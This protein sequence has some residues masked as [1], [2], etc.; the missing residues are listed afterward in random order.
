MSSGCFVFLR[1]LYPYS[2]PFPGCLKFEPNELFLK[3]REENEFWYLASKLDG[4]VGCVP[5]NYVKPDKQDDQAA[6]NCA[7]KALSQFSKSSSDLK[8]KEDILRILKRLAGVEN[9]VKQTQASKLYPEPRSSPPTRASFPQARQNHPLTPKTV[10]T[11]IAAQL[12]DVLRLGTNAKYEECQSSLRVLL[13]LLSAHLPDVMPI[14]KALDASL[15]DSSMEERRLWLTQSPDWYFLQRYFDSV[16]RLSEDD[17]ESN[18]QLHDD[19]LIQQQLLDLLND[20][21]LKADPS[22]IQLFLS[23]KNYEPLQ[24]LIKLYHRKCNS[25]VRQKLLVTVEACFLADPNC[26]SVCIT[27]PFPHELIRELCTH[28]GDLDIA[29]IARCLYLLTSLLAKETALPVDLREQINC[30]FLTHVLRFIGPIGSVDTTSLIDFDP[31]NMATESSSVTLEPF[32]DRQ[33]QH[34]AAILLLSCNWHFCFIAAKRSTGY[35]GVSPSL[36]SKIPL[37]E[38]LISQPSASQ[39][40]LELVVQ[41]FN[42][43]VDPM[44]LV[45]S[46]CFPRSARV[47]RLVR[48]A[49]V[50]AHHSSPSEKESNA[51]A[52]KALEGDVED[53]NSSSFADPGYYARRFWTESLIQEKSAE[54][55][56][57]PT[58]VSPTTPRNSIMKLLF[59]LFNTANTAELI[60]R[61]DRNVIID[62]INRHIGNLKSR[63]TE[64]VLDYPILLG[65]IIAHSDYL[66]SGAHRSGELI[67]NLERLLKSGS[68]EAVNPPILE[69]GLQI[70]RISLDRLRAVCK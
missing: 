67:Q 51:A 54:L 55:P 14:T 59:D 6:I 15:S 40:F 27:S 1:S 30:K 12:V 47:D 5:Y 48:W 18:W 36:V 10:P 38:A 45:R 50:V 9:G 68:F 22:L 57:L 16:A 63:E 64:R 42:R 32:F 65:L 49:E 52:T 31:F 34:A 8:N 60:F 28:E 2:G 41:A 66:S 25:S 21:L 29:H 58:N 56:T 33:L 11:N 26:S 46:T 4:T 23:L 62:V 61:N 13:K 37:L 7:S 24:H 3:I 43:D 44:A 70:A 53:M 17:H 35:E 20:V 69:R 39:N 19:S